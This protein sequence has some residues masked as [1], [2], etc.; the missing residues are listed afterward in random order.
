MNSLNSI[1]FPN[2]THNRG[3]VAVVEVLDR[4]RLHLL[5]CQLWVAVMIR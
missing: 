5:D 4:E 3:R 2:L 1:Q